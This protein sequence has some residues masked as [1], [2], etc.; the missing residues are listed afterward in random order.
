MKLDAY[1]DM[2]G[3]EFG[4]ILPTVEM[5]QEGLMAA[6]SGGGA[7]LLT[8]WGIKAASDAVDLDTR[9]ENPLMRAFITSWSP[10]ASARSSTARRF[11]SETPAPTTR[12]ST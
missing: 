8:S 5:V 7:I 9:V 6:A 2:S 11:R 10:R 12:T 4:Q 3:L 1:D